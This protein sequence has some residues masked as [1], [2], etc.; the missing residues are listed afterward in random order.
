M[1]VRD[2]FGVVCLGAALSCANAHAEDSENLDIGP[3]TPNAADASD[4]DAVREISSSDVEIK[5][6]PG[7]KYPSAAKKQNLPDSVC[8]VRFFVN[9]DG[10]P[11]E[12]RVESGPEVFHENTL[13][14][15]KKWRFEPYVVDEEPVNVQFVVNFKFQKR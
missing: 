12:V 9:Q 4:V 15:A 14:A 7:P 11:Y 1:L 13:A 10:V 8:T 6:R 5:R 3:A 2:W